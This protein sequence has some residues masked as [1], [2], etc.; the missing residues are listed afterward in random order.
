MNFIDRVV[1]LLWPKV[2]AKEVARMEKEMY[3]DSERFCSHC[4][5]IVKGDRLVHAADCVR[6]QF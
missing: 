2:Y 5:G 6:L 3:R 4:F 1:R